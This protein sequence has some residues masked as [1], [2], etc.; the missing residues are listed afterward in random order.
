MDDLL[1]QDLDIAITPTAAGSFRFRVKV[2]YSD[3]I[4]AGY[5]DTLDEAVT[6]MRANLISHIAVLAGEAKADAAAAAVKAEL[7]AEGG[8]DDGDA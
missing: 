8:D 7:E 2:K 3:T 6:A 4:A 5:C 1:Q